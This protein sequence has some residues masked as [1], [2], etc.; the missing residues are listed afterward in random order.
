M[1][2]KGEGQGQRKRRG[3]SKHKTGTSTKRKKDAS[4]YPWGSMIGQKQTNKVSIVCN[5][6]NGLITCQFGNKKLEYV[7][8]DL[9]N[10]KSD[11]GSFKEF[12]RNG[13]IWGQEME[14][15]TYSI[16]K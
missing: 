2:I 11:V 12:Q 5:N 7:K 3:K 16:R 6:L 14:Y 10:I 1:V 15:M 13:H 4:T 9:R 8:G